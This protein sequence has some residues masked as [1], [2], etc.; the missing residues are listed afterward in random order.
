MYFQNINCRFNHKPLDERIAKKKK[1]KK[2]K[3]RLKG[4]NRKEKKKIGERR[5]R[6][7]KY[8]DTR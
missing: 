6:V 5:V 2:R 4:R 8:T 1:K 7:G 3:E